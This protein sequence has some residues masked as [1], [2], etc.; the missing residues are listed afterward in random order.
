[1]DEIKE[2]EQQFK[3]HNLSN[4]KASYEGGCHLCTMI[5]DVLDEFTDLGGVP[6][7]ETV[8]LRVRDD[9]FG[10]EC[11]IDVE[12]GNRPPDYVDQIIIASSQ[13]ITNSI[14]LGLS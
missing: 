1:L 12:L 4:L 3:F 10:T 14:I 2:D 13:G 6:K 7:T 8:S 9:G 11:T 5:W